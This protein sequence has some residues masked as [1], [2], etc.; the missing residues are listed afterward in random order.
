MYNSDAKPYVSISHWGMF[1]VTPCKRSQEA[2]NPCKEGWVYVPHGSEGATSDL[3]SE[4]VQ[5]RIQWE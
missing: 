5:R 2:Y 1:P 4:C 3:C